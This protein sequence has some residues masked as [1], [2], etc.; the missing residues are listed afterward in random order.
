MPRKG[1]NPEVLPFDPTDPDSLFH[2]VTEPV[3]E[4][5]QKI[6]PAWFSWSEHTMIKRFEIDD[7][8][9]RIRISFWDEYFL[10]KDQGRPMMISR[11]WQGACS[12]RYWQDA[13]LKSPKKLCFILTV[14][15]DYMMSM[16]ALHYLGV[17]RLSEIMKFPLTNKEG[18]PNLT[19]ADRVMKAF[20]LI[21]NRV[22]GLA[23]QRMQVEQKSVSY[24]I[25]KNADE[26]I[27]T[28]KD[29]ERAILEI[30]R[31]IK[32]EKKQEVVK[33]KVLPAAETTKPTAKSVQAALEVKTIKKANG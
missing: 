6:N 31:K 27:E 15:A 3:Q 18:K 8:A 19:T 16:K 32:K 1:N 5:M 2:M 21:D 33:K 13:I 24:N 25:T 4:A 28:P 29:L 20:E 9:M 12:R 11:V 30:E 7:R 10:A 17:A 14:P 23:V 22:K 26:V